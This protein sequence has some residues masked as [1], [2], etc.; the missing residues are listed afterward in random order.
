MNR[1]L[2]CALLTIIALALAGCGSREHAARRAPAATSPAQPYADL[3]DRPI[4]SL[5]PAQVED[6]LAGRG[7]GY[8]LAAEL[9]HYPGPRH[10]L[11][12]RAELGLTA[13]QERAA[14]ET[15]DAMERDAQALGRQL[16]AAE[17]ALN[18]AF[19]AGTLTSVELDRLTTDI[20]ALDGR[21]RAVH[22]AAHLRMKE[23]LTVEQVKRYD[24]LRGYPS[25]DGQPAPTRSDTDHRQ[26]HGR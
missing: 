14:Q 8:A 22:L 5:A 3:T 24:H 4:K 13:A 10:V 7:A 15:F 2:H 25:A 26:H 23:L 12:L 11:E 18:R 6:L 20:S 17:T 1:R 21:L 16:V 19:D 9:N